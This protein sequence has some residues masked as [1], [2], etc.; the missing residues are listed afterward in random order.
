MLSHKQV[1]W[2]SGPI[3]FDKHGRA[4][5]DRLA[6]PF[7]SFQIVRPVITRRIKQ[8]LGVRH[9]KVQESFLQNLRYEWL[10]SIEVRRYRVT[11]V[12]AL[13]PQQLWFTH[14]GFRFRTDLGRGL[15]EKGE[16]DLST[17]GIVKHTYRF[18]CLDR[19]RDFGGESQAA[20]QTSVQSTAAGRGAFDKRRSCTNT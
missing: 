13:R 5:I 18:S 8:E 9:F 12:S 20:G 15:L 6:G 14:R 1:S 4:D 11:T 19:I 17:T 7:R 2:S 3:R 10:K 16:D